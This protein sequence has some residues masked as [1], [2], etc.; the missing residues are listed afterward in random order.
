MVDRGSNYGTA[1]Q[2]VK[3]AGDG[4]PEWTGTLT[5]PDDVLAKYAAPPVTKDSGLTTVDLPSDM[6]LKVTPA[7]LAKMATLKR[8][9]VLR[10]QETR[11]TAQDYIAKAAADPDAVV[12]IERGFRRG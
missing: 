4:Q 11:A 12:T 5:A 3:A 7:T 6:K 9:L 10:E 2:L 1:F 8:D